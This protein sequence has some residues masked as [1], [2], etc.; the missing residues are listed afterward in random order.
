MSQHGLVP[1]KRMQGSLT[2]DGYCGII[3]HVF[4]HYVLG[5]PFPDGCFPFQH[6]LSPIHTSRA[7]KRLIEARGL[8]ELPWSPKGAD[9]NIIEQAWHG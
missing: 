5:G 7:V 3:D 2:S 4:L 8:F 6:D 9:L 1:I